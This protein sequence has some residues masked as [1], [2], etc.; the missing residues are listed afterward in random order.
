METN[1]E[2]II[3]FVE[4]WSSLDAAK[5]SE[6]FLEDGSYYNMPMQ[7]IIGR[8]N[9]ENFISSFIANWT[10]TTWD[11]LNITESGNFVFCERL[12]RTKTITGNVDLPC[13]GIF[14]MEQGKIKEWKDYFDMNT[15]IQAMN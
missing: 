12:D 11:I 3:E 15:F 13:M 10:E 6:Y 9:I 2:I 4:T 1:K 8:E 14:E 5:I 7:P